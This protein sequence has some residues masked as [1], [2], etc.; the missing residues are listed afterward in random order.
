MS[1]MGNAGPYMELSIEDQSAFRR[2]FSPE[3][4]VRDGKV[5][6]PGEGYGWGVTIREEWLSEAEYRSD[7]S[8]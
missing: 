2:M 7:E 1:A 3:L 6:I 8:G 5:E 4:V